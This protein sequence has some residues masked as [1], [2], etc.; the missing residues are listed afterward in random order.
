M[1]KYF[2]KHDKLFR[3]SYAVFLKNIIINSDEY[4]RTDENDAYVIALDS[5]WGTGKTYFL[6]M[7][8]SYLDGFLDEGK[9]YSGYKQ[10]INFIDF[11]AWENDF[12]DNAF[13]PLMV[14][15]L[16]SDLLEKEKDNKNAEEVLKGIYKAAF[17]V[18]KGFIKKKLEDYIGKDTLSEVENELSGPIRNY[19]YNKDD[20][21]PDYKDFKNNIDTLRDT[22][23]EYISKFNDGKKLLIIIDELDR[24]KPIFAIQLL[25]IVKHLFNIKGLVFLFTV[26]I[27]QLSHSIRTIY[28]QEMDSIGYL[29]RFF[30]YISRV[31]KADSRIYIEGK[32]EQ[33]NDK[34]EIFGNNDSDIFNYIYDF[35]VELS[36]HYRLSI[37]DLDT[38]FVTYNIMLNSFLKEYSNL[39][40]HYIY[41]YFVTMKY[42]KVEEFNKIFIKDNKLDPKLYYTDFVKEHEFLKNVYSILDEYIYDINYTIY[43]NSGSSITPLKDFNG[44]NLKIDSISQT[45]DGKYKANLVQTRSTYYNTSIEINNDFRLDEILFSPDIIKWDDIKD[46]MYKDYIHQQLEMFNFI[47][48]EK[49]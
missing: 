12:W 8:K 41:L 21:F 4:K 22:L 34:Y 5:A 33:L 37:R 6:S 43:V 28:G 19:L 15:I 44:N 29:C 32:I 48:N 10:E 42:K 26:D 38:I 20:L 47:Q 45:D 40:A 7:F 2:Y 13:E 16:E 36:N 27:E 14:R 3:R 11:N 35:I 1:Y 46:L 9:Q 30:D 17:K 24:C 25:E 31:P 39:E 49:R 18:G 23:S